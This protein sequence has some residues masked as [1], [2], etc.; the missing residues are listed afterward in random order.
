MIKG[1]DS[2]RTSWTVAARYVVEVLRRVGPESRSSYPT[3]TT[4]KVV[5]PE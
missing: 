4:S 2:F 1:H 3:V 5:T